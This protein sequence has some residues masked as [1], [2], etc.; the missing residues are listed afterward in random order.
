MFRNVMAW[1]PGQHQQDGWIDLPGP[2]E[3]WAAYSDD[4]LNKIGF[5]FDNRNRDEY[6]EAFDIAIRTP[7]KP[8]DFG[9]IKFDSQD[10]VTEFEPRFRA[11]L[12]YRM[13]HID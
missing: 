12:L 5:T 9:L 2:A 13:L 7:M 11:Q 8:K 1:K 6:M 4:E 10:L 3:W